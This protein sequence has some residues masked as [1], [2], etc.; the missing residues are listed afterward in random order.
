MAQFPFKRITESDEELVELSKLP[1]P[2]LPQKVKS[3]NKTII[4]TDDESE[5]IGFDTEFEASYFYNVATCFQLQNPNAESFEIQEFCQ[6]HANIKVEDNVDLMTEVIKLYGVISET[7]LRS[8]IWEWIPN[9]YVKSR[10]IMLTTREII[11][12][13]IDGHLT[14]IATDEKSM[15]KVIKN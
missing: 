4:L 10:K 5:E 7:D 6:E 11:A 12:E 15:N 8:T 9:D 1:K 14:F 13:I 2:K 3:E